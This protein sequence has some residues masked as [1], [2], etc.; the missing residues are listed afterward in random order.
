MINTS[1]KN[2]HLWH[3]ASARRKHHINKSWTKTIESFS[4]LLVLSQTW[5][6]C[7]TRQRKYMQWCFINHALHKVDRCLLHM[8]WNIQSWSILPTAFSSALQFLQC[9]L[10]SAVY[11]VQ[12]IQCSAE[13]TDW[14]HRAPWVSSVPRILRSSEV[15]G[16][17]CKDECQWTKRRK[18]VNCHGPKL[19]TSGSWLF[20][21]ILVNPIW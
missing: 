12:L 3:Q 16:S 18:P 7:K 21:Q 13:A 20:G 17:Q 15:S 9:S 5:C 10:Y 6:C 1:T 8:Q 19:L 11:T 4:F 2:C 14:N